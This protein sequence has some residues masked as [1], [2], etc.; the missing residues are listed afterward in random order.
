[1]NK[2]DDDGKKEIH[3]GR[4]LLILGFGAITIALITTS[5]SLFF[6]QKGDIYIDRS[7]PGY[8]TENEKHNIDDDIQENYSNEGKITDKSLAEYVEELNRVSER[9]DA[10]KNDFGPDPLSDDNLMI[11]SNDDNED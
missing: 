6:Y 9:I 2:A 1:M 4:N 10:S 3:G 8:I 7:R 5:I 11:T